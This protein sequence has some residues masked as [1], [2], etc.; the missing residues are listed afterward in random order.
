MPPS[1]PL[2]SR[3]KGTVTVTVSQSELQEEQKGWDERETERE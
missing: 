3:K 2:R 1:V